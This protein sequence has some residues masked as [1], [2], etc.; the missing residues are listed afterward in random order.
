MKKLLAAVA[1]S[2]FALTS[3][4]PMALAA[5]STVGVH[6]AK[7]QNVH[8]VA[9]KKK[10]ATKTKSTKSTKKKSPTKSS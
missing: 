4:V 2:A 10:K 6:Q 1:V 5:P 8:K 3:A 9:T 7:H